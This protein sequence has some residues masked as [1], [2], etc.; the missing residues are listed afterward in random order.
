MSAFT[1]FINSRDREDENSNLN[2]CYYYLN[3]YNL[4]SV[5][6]IAIAVDKFVMPNLQYNVNTHTRTIKFKENGGPEITAVLPLGE[7]DADTLATALK[8][9]MD[10]AG[11]STYTI[12]WDT[13][14][15]K[16]T[17][18]SGANTTQLTTGT[19]NELLG[20]VDNSA[21]ST[22]LTADYP[23]RLEGLNAILLDIP[24]VSSKNAYTSLIANS[25]I[26]YVPVIVAYGEIIT[27]D[28]DA[29]DDRATVDGEVLTQIRI[30]L[31]DEKGR[32]LDI[33][34]NCH[35]QLSLRVFLN[36]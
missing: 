19:I 9:A 23:M 2:D 21:D 10:A 36:I 14:N 3:E 11:T 6:R 33:P 18:S 27:H 15:F 25:V 12:T 5:G 20:F 1:I 22:S 28:N 16:F 8:I 17:I 30:K 7:Y 31:V 29:M 32:K 24:G 13:T 4:T 26:D 34:A 35:Y